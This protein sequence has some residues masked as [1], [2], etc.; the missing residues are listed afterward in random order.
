MKIKTSNVIALF[1]AGFFAKDIIDNIFFLVIDKYP[2]E[3]FG[4]QITA[5]SHKIMLMVS[6]ILTTV[7]LYYGLKKN[8]TLIKNVN[9]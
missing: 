4:F 2:I 9:V 5:S 6:I 7:F 1:F 8:K 3:I